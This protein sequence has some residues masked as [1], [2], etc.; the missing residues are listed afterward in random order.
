VSDTT[1]QIAQPPARAEMGL[2]ENGFVFCCFNNRHKI[3]P[4]F[5]DAWMRILRAVDGSVLWLVS[6]NAVSDANLKHEA[7]ARGVAPERIVFMPG[8]RKTEDYLARYLLADLYLDTLP[9]N[10]ITTAADAL[11]AGL[12]ILTCVGNSFGG[13]GASSLL[14]AVGMPELIAA[15][16]ADYETAALKLARDGAAL[17]ALKQKLARDRASPPLFNTP[18][19]CRNLEAAYL[20]MW[21]RYQRGDPPAAF[22]V[23]PVA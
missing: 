19:F 13:R 2:P 21:Q 5:F 7:Q 16:L 20:A 3:T 1:R 6:G 18:R 12:P 22:A 11:W 17:S 23:A 14:H 10:A 4:P 9:Y 8:V 15:S